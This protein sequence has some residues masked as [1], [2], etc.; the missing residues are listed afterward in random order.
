MIDI[1]FSI[2]RFDEDGDCVECG[3]YLHFGDTTIR[4]G[5]H[6][7]DAVLLKGQIDKIVG[8][9]LYEYGGML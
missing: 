4:I 3:I 9:I 1:T 8:K 5:N 6:V 2:N 7:K